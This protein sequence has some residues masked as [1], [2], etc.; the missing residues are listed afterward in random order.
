MPDLCHLRA[1]NFPRQ[2]EVRNPLQNYS[3]RSQFSGAAS[4]RNLPVCS[5]EQLRLRLRAFPRTSSLVPVQQPICH[6]SIWL[7]RCQTNHSVRLP[8]LDLSP[9]FFG[10]ALTPCRSCSE[11]CITNPDSCSLLL[12]A[13]RVPEPMSP[14]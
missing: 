1:G 9:S 4:R 2:R 14:Q 11:I 12:K 10:I 7:C 3:W 6:A 5:S 13:D 8:N